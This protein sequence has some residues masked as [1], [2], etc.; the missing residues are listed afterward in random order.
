MMMK[1]FITLLVVVASIN[2]EEWW[3]PLGLTAGRQ[4][5]PILAK[6]TPAVQREFF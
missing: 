2:A 1:S 5:Q 6:L 3:D 4:D